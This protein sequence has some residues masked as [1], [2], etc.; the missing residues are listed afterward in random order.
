[1]T[2][3]QNEL[4]IIVRDAMNIMQTPFDIRMG[5]WDATMEIKRRVEIIITR[6]YEKGYRNKEGENII[7]N[8]NDSK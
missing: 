1:M 3:D 8:T 5:P 4:E 6:A 2:I 7:N